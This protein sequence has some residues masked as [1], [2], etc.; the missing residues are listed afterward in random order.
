MILE[1]DV[2]YYICTNFLSLR[3]ILAWRSVN[4]TFGRMMSESFFRNIGDDWYSR[5]FWERA[6][7]RPKHI[8]LPLSSNL[9]ELKRIEEF[10][11][12]LSRVNNRRWTPELF[13]LYWER[14]DYFTVRRNNKCY[15]L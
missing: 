6:N 3:Q 2:C 8:S 4:K 10:Q 12:I 1:E 9:L 11:E 5:E 7:L 15:T 14:V 13:Y